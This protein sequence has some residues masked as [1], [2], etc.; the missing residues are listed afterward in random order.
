MR[1]VLIHFLL[2][3][4]VCTAQFSDD[5]SDGDFTNNPVWSGDVSTFTIT[6][7]QL[8]TNAGVLA[9]TTDYY[10]SVP[11]TLANAAQWEFFVNLKFATSGS[12]YADIYLIADNAN[13][14]SP[15][16]NGYFVRIGDTQ[17][18]IS[19]HIISAGVSTKIIDG[20][21]S[22]VNSST[23]NPFKIRVTR[24]AANQ[25]ILEYDD[26]LTGTFL[27]GG[28]VTDA[29][30]LT[31]GFFGVKIRQSNA[32]SPANNHFFDDFVVSDLVFD[33]TPPKPVSVS[34]NSATSLDVLFDEKVESVSAQTTS[35]YLVNNS[36]GN[37][38]EAI[39]QPDEK[40]V[41]L[42][43]AGPFPNAVTSLLTVTGVQDNAGNAI[44][45]ESKEFFF[46]QSVPPDYKDIVITEI[47]ADPTPA[48]GLP[49][50]EYLELYNRSNK[51]FDLN[52][53]KISDGSSTG[54]LPPHLLYPG[55]YVIL[56]STSSASLFTSFG[57]ALAIPNFPTLNN[58]GD[59][60]TLMDNSNAAIDFVHYLD[61]WYRDED[62]KQGGY[63]LELIDP[64][65]PCGEEN[66]WTSAEAST[67]GTPGTQN[68]VFENKPDLTG[69]MLVSA[70]PV[71]S[72][73]ILVRFN[74][75]LSASLPAITDFTISP[76]LEVSMVEFSDATLQ[77]FTISLSGNLQSG[78]RYVLTA[79]H[80]Y[81]CNGNSLQTEFSTAI[82]GLPEEA[83]PLDVVINEI[84]FNP[85]PTGVDFV[86]IFNPSTKY[87][88]L[89]NWSIAN[90]T[91][92]ALSNPRVIST[93][94]Y[95]L[96]PLRHLV[97]TVNKS[98]VKG[99]YIQAV[100]ENLFQVVSLPSFND[101]EGTVA[102][103]DSL[104]KIIDSFS[105]KDDYHSVFI[106]EEEGVSLERISFQELTQSESNWKSASATAGF[107]TPGYVNSNTV[108]TSDE[109][110]VSVNPEIFEPISGNPDFTKIEY[111]FNQ[112]GLVGNIRIL[113]FQGREIKQIANNTTLSTSGFFRWDGDTNDGLKAR[114]GYYVVWIEVFDSTGTIKTYRKR[115]VIASRSN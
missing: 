92:G 88:N 98:V 3:A 57:S 49:E 67:G 22:S 78:V 14:L 111:N 42:T 15:A 17:D 108:A 34:V 113:D 62:K 86:E 74:E 96:E 26:G 100:E 76:P 5:F 11:S 58:A 7:G 106:K 82:F 109:S 63:S 47:F 56:S 13:L 77:N 43:F 59:A 81:D 80:I 90:Y 1:Y 84:L 37:P 20:P 103:V 25:W 110:T 114:Q 40:T 79:Q 70:I 71:S 31:S 94:D 35:N 64:A 48:I 53:W 93:Q 38:A 83:E 8:N 46:F 66:N 54:T 28:T 36:I 75:K 50:A 102:L 18:D 65:N 115:V 19:L 51:I 97:F 72:T 107:A 61:T 33:T 27:P 45:S 112:G 32:T 52:N 23:S 105:Y 104:G 101:T 85:R 2:I 10:L 73:Q 41:R 6:S 69:P 12:N 55:A 99:E 21:N 60:L 95:L 44:A 29:T 16:L 91:D 4:H 39:L 30:F 68:S 87:I 24:D 89:K 9:A